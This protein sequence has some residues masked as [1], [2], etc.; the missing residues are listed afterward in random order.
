MHKSLLHVEG[1]SLKAK[2]G[3][4]YLLQDITFEVFPGDRLAIIGAT[5][6]G[7]TSLLR[8]LNR[9]SEPNQGKI[10]FQNQE[11]SQIQPVTLRRQVHLLL[12]EPKLLGMN[13]KEALA[14]PLQLQKLDPA[15]IQ[16]R[17]VEVLSQLHIPN[18]WLER[19]EVQLSVGQR[20]LVA[21]A[22]SLILEPEILLLDEPTSAL[23]AAKADLLVQT[24]NVLSETGTRAILMVNHQLNVVQKFANRVLYLQNGR[25]IADL[26]IKEVRWQEISDRLTETEADLN[27]EWDDEVE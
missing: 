3:P 7:K 10:R 14:Y 25:L 12:Q 1:V 20:Q 5:G 27:R 18:D 6:A 11:Y 8:L 4:Y 16:Q 9:L 17:L 15:I 22:R 24:L 23:D 2:V 26:P 19:T 21:I 13:V